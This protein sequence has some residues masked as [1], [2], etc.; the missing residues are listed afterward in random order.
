MLCR[1]NIEI[2]IIPLAFRNG[3]KNG[4]MRHLKIL[5]KC[6]AQTSSHQNR[7]VKTLNPREKM[8]TTFELLWPFD[9]QLF[10]CNALF[11]VYVIDFYENK[12]SIYLNSICRRKS[13]NYSNY[14]LK[15]YGEY[16]QLLI[17][18]IGFSF[19]VCAIT[20]ILFW[21]AQVLSI[22]HLKLIQRNA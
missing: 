2:N 21:Y 6:Y 14:R 4:K 19:S 7:N 12:V 15:K 13:E 9:L 17:S 5:R 1:L 10:Q 11:W 18:S 20:I 8:H 16:F 22:G 3:G